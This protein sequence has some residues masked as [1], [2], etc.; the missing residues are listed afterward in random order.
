MDHRVGVHVSSAA[1]VLLLAG[2]SAAAP[3]QPVTLADAGGPSE[4]ARP[5]PPAS[6]GAAAAPPSEPGPRITIGE[7]EAIAL[8]VVGDGWV[9]RI[10]ADDLDDVLPVWEVSV[11]ISAGVD[12]ELTLD[13]S[14]GR[15]LRDELYD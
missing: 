13:M 1:T 14:D 7:A 8:E 6:T 2:C 15:V 3:V 5:E 10:E 9:D 11:E 12:R 4:S